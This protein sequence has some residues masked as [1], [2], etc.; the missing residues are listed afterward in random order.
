[1]QSDYAIQVAVSLCVAGGFGYIELSISCSFLLVFW[2]FGCECTP[3]GGSAFFSFGI[4]LFH[5]HCSAVFDR[6]FGSPH[7]LGFL[8][9]WLFRFRVLR[10]ALLLPPVLEKDERQSA[11][12]DYTQ[13][14]SL[15][16]GNT[17]EA[18]LDDRPCFP[19]SCSRRFSTRSSRD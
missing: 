14:R 9:P 16:T 11:R 5:P 19:I 4:P 1:M 17:N 13:D 15:L 18:S 10:L 8:L 12:Q 2:Y 3:T 6:N 7:F